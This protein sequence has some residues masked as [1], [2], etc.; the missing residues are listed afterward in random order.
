SLALMAPAINS[1]AGDSWLSRAIEVDNAGR[2]RV[3]L[4][5]YW[6]KQDAP[7]IAQRAEPSARTVFDITISLYNDPA[8]DSDP[9]TDSGEPQEVYE[10]IVRHF[11]DSVCEQ[12]NG[13]HRL[14]KVRLFTSNNQQAAADIVWTASKWPQAHASGFG[15]SGRHIFFGDVFPGGTGSSDFDMLANPAV[16][17]Y[18]LGHEWAH[19]AYGLFDEYVGNRFFSFNPR[20][21]LSSDIAVAP[22]VM[23]QQ[24]RAAQG[25][26]DWLNF[27]TSNNIGNTARTAQGRVYG[28]SA[29]DV[30]VQAQSEDP[31]NGR[32]RAQPDRTQYTSLAGV[33]PTL[34]DNWVKIEL[35]AEQ[36]SCR[37]DLE[38]L[39]VEGDLDLQIVLD[40]SGSMI[41]TPIANAK[42]AASLLVDTVADGQTALGVASFAGDL[43]QDSPMQAIPDPG[44]MVK[45]QIKSVINNLRAGGATRLY[46]GALRALSEI[47]AYQSANSTSAPQVV[48][49]LSD[50]RD[51]SSSSSEQDV[52]TTYQAANV[53]L[54]TFGFGD[55]SPT[56]S[57]LNM[58]NATGGQYTFSPTD[59]SQITQAFLQANAVASDLKNVVD[60]Q[61][62]LMPGVMANIPLPVDSGLESLSVFFNYDG[63]ISDV[64]P[65]VVTPA[66]ATLD[67]IDYDC[68]QISGSLTSCSAQ[69]GEAA[70]AT[71][72]A[73]AWGIELANGAT[74]NRQVDLYVAGLPGANGSFSARVAGAQGN[75]IAYP[76]PIVVT[77]S[78]IK[79]LPITGV[80]ISAEITDPTGAAQSFDMVDD[81]TAGD[82]VADDGIYSAILGY[83][84]NGRYQ[85]EVRVDNDSGSARFTTLGLQP[86]HLP[87]VLNGTLPEVQPVPA[88][89]ENFSRISRTSIVVTG[90]PSSDG[91]TGFV[92]AD[93]LF[94]DNRGVEGLMDLAGDED[95]F[96]IRN[97]DTTAP[98]SVRVT[99]LSL[100][101]DPVLTVFAADT[102][103]EL[104]T[105]ASLPANES[106]TGYLLAQIPASDLTE[107]LYAVISHRDPD[108]ATGGYA[109][110]A[111]APINT[112]V[113]PNAFPEPGADSLALVEGDR[114]Q[115]DVLANDLDADGD[116]LSTD[117][118][119]PSTSGAAI[120]ITPA[121]EL[122]YDTSARPFNLAPG[123][124][125]TELVSYVVTDGLAYRSGDVNVTITG[126]T[127]PQLG[128]D[129]ATTD[130]NDAV[131]LM[132]LGND[133]DV[134][135]QALTLTAID[136]SQT[137][138]MVT[139]NGDGTATYNPANAF[140]SLQQG[141]T[142]TT[143]FRYTVTDSGGLSST[144]VATVTVRGIAPPSNPPSSS[145]GGGSTNVLVLL[146]LGFGLIARRRRF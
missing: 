12:T 56:G 92:T 35:P 111:G 49:L 9:S 126:N 43:R 76:E 15:A 100:D 68:L 94:A 62:S 34:T 36:V 69:I 104:V 2:S 145:G 125:T 95:Y 64:T 81:G 134:D 103:T 137:D 55:A 119:A 123:A 146:L 65:T 133:S 128:A 77:M 84:A 121:G 59:L 29:W 6:Q 48:F 78:V 110:S 42:Q 129:S 57:L 112:D 86:A 124:T 52:I 44:D 66:G 113:P 132:L 79:D 70:L 102:T 131:T 141:Q 38:I 58:A 144:A 116:A 74:T 27:S 28:K 1:A 7:L 114:G 50:G 120:S 117:G 101:M 17:G 140:P 33:A 18:T 21:P 82:A 22:S 91:N 8:G 54:F 135:N 97:V 89:T 31:K 93:E 16:A 122:D 115:I 88:L 83:E 39:W 24:D 53:P 109:V 108:V 13:S 10:E 127:P 130:A 142:A 20:R 32:R 99:S 98:L 96:V 25:D 72:G 85:V 75:E 139:N 106:T 71:G 143:T 46:D 87:A 19:Y 60:T 107:T 23:N 37:G 61:Q 67:T 138:G 41:G 51:T 26:F 47:E 40:R 14:G 4:P 63:V 90:R 45:A 11:A 73:G 5:T 80:N 30:L 136:D 105:A 118:I 3:S